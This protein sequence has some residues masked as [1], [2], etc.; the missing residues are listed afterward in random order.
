MPAMAA[1]PCSLYVLPGAPTQADLEVGYATRG[2]QLVSC[3]AARRLAI[4]THE[5]EHTLEDMAQQGQR[6][7]HGWFGR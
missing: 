6:K 1:L 5:A 2:A 7:R 4:Q 3:D